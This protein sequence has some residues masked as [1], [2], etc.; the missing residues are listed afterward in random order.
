MCH[1]ERADPARMVMM[2]NGSCGGVEGGGGLRVK[3]VEPLKEKC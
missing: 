1:H 3:V 2:A